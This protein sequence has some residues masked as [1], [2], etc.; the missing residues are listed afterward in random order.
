[1]HLFERH[2]KFVQN[3]KLNNFLI[4]KLNIMN[5][6]LISTTG[7][8]C[9]RC[10]NKESFINY[11]DSKTGL[12]IK[13]SVVG[14]CNNENCSYHINP[15]KN[16]KKY[17]H[18]LMMKTGRWSYSNFS[19]N[20]QSYEN[21]EVDNFWKGNSSA[22]NFVSFLHTVFNKSDVK[23]AVAKYRIS[24]PGFDSNNNVLWY[25]D[26]KDNLVDGK[27]ICFDK[28]TGKYLSNS[29]GNSS[30][31]I[32]NI[33]LKQHDQYNDT[34]FGNYQY[35]PTKV[36]F[37][38]HLLPKKN[39]KQ[40]CVVESE[41]SAIIASI[42]LPE[43]LWVATGGQGLDYDLVKPIIGHDVM[44]FPNN[45]NY[46]EWYSNAKRFRF[47]LSNFSEISHN[48]TN[49]NLLDFFISNLRS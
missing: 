45:D 48:Q 31:L 34:Y 13:D 32:S 49:T 1:M 36:L 27:V 7:T 5:I 2:R 43:H 4:K 19:T 42:V 24:S 18:D 35:I 21:F 17:L 40:I 8:K 14:K 47:S 12:P 20:N 38:L 28:D 22:S 23:K 6:K 9:P 26:N 10:K 33:K 30:I 41:I 44:L 11:L 3:Q 37:G 46:D 16:K 25:Y 39:Y 15:T 29:S